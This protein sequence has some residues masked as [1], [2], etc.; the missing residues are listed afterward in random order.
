MVPA[1]GP[2][3]IEFALALYIAFLITAFGWRSWVQYRRTGDH[4]F[5]GFSGGVAS[6]EWLPGLLFTASLTAFLGAPVAT[7][8]DLLGCLEFPIWILVLGIILAIAGLLLVL[9]AQLNMGASWHVGVDS[10]ER[11]ELITA[12]LFAL[13]RKPI[14]SAL[15]VFTLGYALLVPNA[16]SAVR[17][18]LG[19]IG[20]ELQVRFV[21][22]PFLLRTHGDSDS[23]YAYRVGRFLPLVGCLPERL[24]GRGRR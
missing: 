13:V 15:G 5:R 24:N 7:L 2:H 18:L 11:T 23:E 9:L 20:L 17:L 12:G 8:V 4:S 6:V 22:E 1:E 3:M 14:F 21:E 10:S 19:A 16:L